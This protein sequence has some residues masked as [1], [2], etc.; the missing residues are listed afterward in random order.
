MGV[1]VSE[2]NSFRYSIYVVS[3]LTSLPQDVCLQA[4]AITLCPTTTAHRQ[5]ID[6]HFKV[7]AHVRGDCHPFHT[8]PSIL[9]FSKQFFQTYSSCWSL[10][11]S[12]Q[13]NYIF[14]KSDAQKKGY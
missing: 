10:L 7:A 5:V 1:S 2:V 12:F 9:L 14:L 3:Y 11:D 4:K 8:H 6:H 13:L